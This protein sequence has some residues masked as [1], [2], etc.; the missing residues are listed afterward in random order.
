M[1][2]ESS[3]LV[4]CTV[5]HGEVIFVYAMA[6]W[7]RH[8]GKNNS[9]S[10]FW[11]QCGDKGVHVDTDGPSCVVIQCTFPCIEVVGL[12]SEC[13]TSEASYFSVVRMEGRH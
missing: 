5:Q 9:T 11:F 4:K 13:K 12:V 1:C 3:L 10:H 8:V 7:C 2:V 6:I